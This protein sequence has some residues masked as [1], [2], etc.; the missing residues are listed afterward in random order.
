MTLRCI[1]D[2]GNQE[3]TQMLDGATHRDGG[4]LRLAEI[5]DAIHTDQEVPPLVETEDIP[6]QDHELQI[7]VDIAGATLQDEEALIIGEDMAVRNAEIRGSFPL[8]VVRSN[9][10]LRA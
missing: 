4:V 9:M 7:L 8:S 10:L 2:V 5:A 1:T 3:Y 6:H